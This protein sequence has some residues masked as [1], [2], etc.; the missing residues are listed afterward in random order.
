MPL[1]ERYIG[2]IRTGAW[3]IWSEAICLLLVLFSLSLSVNKFTPL[4]GTIFFF[5]VAMSRTGLYAFDLVQTNEIQLA[6]K[7]NGKRGRFQAMQMGMQ[8]GVE[9]GKY[10]LVV[11][12]NRPEQ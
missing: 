2:L 5:A 10:G 9:L 12:L 11:I 4:S 3:S 7:E 1:G 8:S 6:L